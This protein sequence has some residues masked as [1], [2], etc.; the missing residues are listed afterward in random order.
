MIQIYYHGSYTRSFT[1][2]RL[3]FNEND[4]I[5]PLRNES[6]ITNKRDPFEKMISTFPL[7]IG[8]IT[9]NIKLFVFSL[10]E[11]KFPFLSHSEKQSSQTKFV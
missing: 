8:K 6:L 10:I 1:H 5:T 9:S 11:M 2:F 3:A 7:F 4:N